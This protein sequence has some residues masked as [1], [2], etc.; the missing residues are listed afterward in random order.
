MNPMARWGDKGRFDGRDQ[1]TKHPGERIKWTVH[2]RKPIS[3][4]V[5]TKL[6]KQKEVKCASK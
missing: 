1:D 5:T 6:Y 2:H 3:F 4:T